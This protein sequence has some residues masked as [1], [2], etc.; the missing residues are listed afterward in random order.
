[1]KITSFTYFLINHRNQGISQGGKIVDKCCISCE[2]DDKS[3]CRQ[4]NERAQFRYAECGGG[5]IGRERGPEGGGSGNI[6]VLL[7]RFMPIIAPF[8]KHIKGQ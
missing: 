8:G 7:S 4:S 3:G 6:F 1:M 2:T 5:T